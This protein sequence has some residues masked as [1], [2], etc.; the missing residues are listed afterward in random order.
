[1]TVSMTDAY[2]TTKKIYHYHNS[3]KF[4]VPLS[5]EQSEISDRKH[6]V[7]RRVSP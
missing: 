6:V 7:H 5:Q 1:M 3:Y 4:Y 2:S